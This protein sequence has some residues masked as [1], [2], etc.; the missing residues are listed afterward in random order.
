MPLVTTAATAAA[1]QE[2]NANGMMHVEE[3]GE[4]ALTLARW[5]LTAWGPTNAG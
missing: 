2:M 5:D 4:R 3:R 1:A